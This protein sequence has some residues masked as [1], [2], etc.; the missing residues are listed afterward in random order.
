MQFGR[1][2]V[3]RAG[4]VATRTTRED[5]GLEYLNLEPCDTEPW[6]N[7]NSG[8]KGKKRGKRGHSEKKIRRNEAGGAAHL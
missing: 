1:D 3:W 6:R 5:S 8:K 2:G 4:V 7:R